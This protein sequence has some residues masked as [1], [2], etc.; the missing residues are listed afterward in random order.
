MNWVGTHNYNAV[1][2]AIDCT[3]SCKS[4]C[5]ICDHDH[6]G[7]FN[8]QRIK[9]QLDMLIY[10]AAGIISLFFFSP[11]DIAKNKSLTCSNVVK[12]NQ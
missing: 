5:H 3:G 12:T 9:I 7:H 11:L 1:V 8:F 2:I 4:N 6:D 10:C